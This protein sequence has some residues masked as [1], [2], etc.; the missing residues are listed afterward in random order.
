[1]VFLRNLAIFSCFF[2]SEVFKNSYKQRKAK[3]ITS[4]S[5]FYDLENPQKFTN[6]VASI[7]DKDGIWVLEQSYLPKMLEQNSFD[8]ICHE[9]LE[10]YAL[11]QIER[12]V[13]N[14]NLK[15]INVSL[16]NI[17]GGSF[18]VEVSHEKSRLAVQNEAISRLKAYERNLN[19]DRNK[20]YEDFAKRVDDIGKKLRHF[21]KE[22]KSKDKEIFVYGASTKGN[23]LLQYFDLDNQLITACAERNTDKFGCMTPG[24]QI[25]IISE[26]EAR[27]RADYFLVL[28]WHFR[29]TFLEREKRFLEKGGKFIFPLPE[30]DIVGYSDLN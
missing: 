11:R 6:D 28:P 18:R 10:Y 1:M 30:V 21:L 4:I 17:N 8:T 15:I 29:E 3:V 14:A 23:V 20:T 12:L 24:S 26:K 13:K 22:E 16:N 7:L 25:P 27:D 9:H 19:L 5:M 2:T